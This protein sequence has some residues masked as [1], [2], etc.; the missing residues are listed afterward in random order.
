MKTVLTLIV[1][2]GAALVLASRPALRGQDATSH[3]AREI[4]ITFDDL[5]RNGPDPGLANTQL[6]TDKLTAIIKARHLPVVG[7]VNESQLYRPGEMDAR[8]ALLNMW[9]DRGAELGNH[10]F[11]HPSLNKIPLEDFEDD[12]IR[13]E[14]VTRMLLARRGM[15]LRY[16]RYPF[17]HTG[18]SLEIKTEFEAFLARHHYTNAPVTLENSDWMFS[19]LYTKAKLGGDRE[20]ADRISAAYLAYTE[21]QFGFLEKLAVEVLG[22]EPRQVMLMHANW[23]NADHLNEI[24]D[25]MQKR[26]YQ[27]VTLQHALKDKAYTLPDTYTGP[28]GATWIE[29]W[30]N[31]KGMGMRVKDEPDP[32]EF[33]MKMYKDL[34]QG[35]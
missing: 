12:L 5:P 10:T 22:Y 20:L 26:G 17:L 2:C 9:L 4:A 25:I 21:K 11:S 16:F 15:K 8:V 28:M 7:M 30:A 18:P 13:G 3:A 29:R 19:A 32:P 1:F 14:N 33:I 23:L 31:S 35:K 24:L 6:M 27:F 34:T